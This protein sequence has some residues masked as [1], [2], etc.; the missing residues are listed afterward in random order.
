MAMIRLAESE[1][2]IPVSP[3]ELDRD[4]WL[5]N[6]ANG[7]IDLRTGELLAHRPDDL[8]TNLVGLEYDPDAKCP[9]WERFLTE[10][11]EPHHDIIPFIQRAAGYSLTGDTRE[12]CLFLLWG[13]GRN[14]KGTFIK[15]ISTALGDYAG[16]ADF[17]TFV[18]RHSDGPR[19]DVANMKGKRF[20]SAQEAREG[21]ALAESLI[22]WLTGGDRIRARRLYE[23]SS[24]FDPTHKIWLATNHKPKIRGTDTAIWSRIKLI[25]FEVSFEG[26]ED[27]SL[28]QT[29]LDELPGILAWAVKGCVEW[30]GKGLDIPESVVRATQEYRDESDQAARFIQDCCVVDDSAQAKARPLYQSYRKWAE[31]AGEEV[32]SETAFGIR[33][34]GRFRKVKKE[35]GSW[36]TG[37]GL[38]LEGQVG[39][40]GSDDGS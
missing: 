18:Q 4:A 21:T 2:G 22:K 9:R 27:K 5:L 14:G 19:D 1:R 8:I 38:S 3:D 39:L 20:I 29:L 23:N 7:T 12:E 16:T 17:S 35:T 10:I 25:P 33:V 11:F 26:R 13:I 32:L 36:Y 31:N 24:E 34:S 6:C 30:Q 15:T 37:I 28:K 40:Q